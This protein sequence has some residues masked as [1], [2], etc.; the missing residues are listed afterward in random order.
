VQKNVG[1]EGLLKL[2]LE[3]TKQ[4]DDTLEEL[5]C[6]RLTA[7]EQALEDLLQARPLEPVLDVTG[8]V[9]E[10]VAQLDIMVDGC[11]RRRIDAIRFAHVQ[12]AERLGD[13]ATRLRHEAGRLR[14]VVGEVLDRLSAL[15]DVP[16]DLSILGFQRI[17]PWSTVPGKTL[18][19]CSLDEAWP[20]WN[21]STGV[22][23]CYATPKHVSLLREAERLENEAQV[24]SSYEVRM[25]GEE[26]ADSIDELL[27]RLRGDPTRLWPK[28]RDIKHWAS[29]VRA[30]AID[31][32][33]VKIETRHTQLTLIWRDGQLDR[34]ASSIAL[35]KDTQVRGVVDQNHINVMTESEH[36]V[37]V[38]GRSEP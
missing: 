27:A 25:A 20:D 19:E 8:R 34:E 17:G 3:L 30:S 18:A 32:L 2:E 31:R 4:Q 1:P 22:R 12:R 5:S 7:G 6:M 14:I 21:G 13:F 38:V 37:H 15:A 9:N 10:R 35:L 33:G 36:E 26:K 23:G 11:R 29:A 28:V 16:Y 24:E